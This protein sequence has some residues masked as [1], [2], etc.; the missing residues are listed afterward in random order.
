VFSGEAELFRYLF[1]LKM[2]WRWARKP[3]P[4]GNILNLVSTVVMAIAT[5][6]MAFIAS[7]TQDIQTAV[8]HL[9]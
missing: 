4:W 3:R 5:V 2:L 8:G 6:V 9:S 7:N 1:S